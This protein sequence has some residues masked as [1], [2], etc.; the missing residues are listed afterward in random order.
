MEANR[1]YQSINKFIDFIHSKYNQVVEVNC[2]FECDDA[3]KNQFEQI[4]VKV[5][6]IK[7]VD[8]SRKII[9]LNLKQIEKLSGGE[10]IVNFPQ[11]NKRKLSKRNGLMYVLV[12]DAKPRTIT[13]DDETFKYYLSYTTECNNKKNVEKIRKQTMTEYRE[14]DIDESAFN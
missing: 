12:I 14:D 6:F 9:Y 10:L 11:N 5:L 2:F 4:C 1:V 8:E 3:F 7:I 13:K